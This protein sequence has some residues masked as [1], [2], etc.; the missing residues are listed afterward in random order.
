MILPAGD[1]PPYLLQRTR[2]APVND[3]RVRRRKRQVGINSGQSAN[4]NQ[5][6]IY[7][8]AAREKPEALRPINHNAQRR[9]YQRHRDVMNSER[10]PECECS[11]IK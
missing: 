7:Q 11:G 6:G 4:R 3:R 9:K 2:I 1:V 10:D 8:S 5:R